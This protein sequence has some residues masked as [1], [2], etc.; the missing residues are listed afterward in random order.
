FI[1]SVPSFEFVANPGQ[2]IADVEAPTGAYTQFLTGVLGYFGELDFSLVAAPPL[3]FD[4]SVITFADLFD[5]ATSIEVEGD[6]SAAA[7]T[8]WDNYGVADSF[9]DTLAVYNIGANDNVGDMGIVANTVDPLQESDYNA[10]LLAVA[11]P[12]YVIDDVGP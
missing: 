5:A 1:V 12:G 2:A 10:T 9:T 7:D 4:G 6:F 8:G 3:N 11:N